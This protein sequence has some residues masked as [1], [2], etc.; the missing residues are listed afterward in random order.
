MA[1][2]VK[3]VAALLVLCAHGCSAGRRS[4]KVGV[5]ESVDPGQVVF[6][7]GRLYYPLSPEGGGQFRITAGNKDDRFAIGNETGDVILKRYLNNDIDP[8]YDLRVTNEK[9]EKRKEIKIR[10]SV[11]DDPNYPPTFNPNCYI[12]PRVRNTAEIWPIMGTLHSFLGYQALYNNRRN[13]SRSVMVLD[14]DRCDGKVYAIYKSGF[15]DDTLPEGT[16]PFFNFECTNDQE[17]ARNTPTITPYWNASYGRPDDSAISPLWFVDKP[18]KTFLRHILMEINIKDM[19]THSPSV[20]KCSIE[21]QAPN[22][23]IKASMVFNI[24]ALGC[25]AG[26]YGGN[27]SEVC[28]C[29]NGGSCHPFNGACKCP[30]GWKGRACDIK[31]P[32]VVMSPKYQN[33]TSGQAVR[34]SC[35]VV[36]VDPVSTFAWALNGKQLRVDDNK[37]VTF[38]G[39]NTKFNR[40]FV[41]ATITV[42]I[43]SLS[44]SGEYACAYRATDG[45]IYRQLAQVALEGKFSLRCDSCFP[46]TQSVSGETIFLYVVGPLAFLFLLTLIIQCC[47]KHKRAEKGNAI[48][49]VTKNDP[50]VKKPL[51]EFP[52]MVRRA[53]VGNE[54]V[55]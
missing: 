43:S 41:N 40:T 19:I 7:V 22:F 52:D 4:F 34:L 18:N 45:M 12:P 39:F 31:D 24:E 14:N 23:G 53:T 11:E 20:Y 42:E 30:D 49:M 13:G 5:S 32:K 48:A 21:L 25:P 3:I 54:Y 2:V 10:I 37:M 47:L 35:E 26:F 8:H 50:D 6:S 46:M 38:R 29:Q 51:A 33:V 28:V 16:T 15:W 27:C 55:V 44:M 17:P 1:V 9:A 36:N